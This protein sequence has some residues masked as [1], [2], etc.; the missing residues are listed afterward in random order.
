[1][2]EFTK[3]SKELSKNLCEDFDP[4][5][6]TSKPIQDIE[7]GTRQCLR[8]GR[9]KDASMESTTSITKDHRDI[10][11]FMQRFRSAKEFQ[12]EFKAP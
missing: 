2:S 5:E 7:V 10:T 6:G 9:L 3:S 11:Q 8:N 4:P 12:T 1:M